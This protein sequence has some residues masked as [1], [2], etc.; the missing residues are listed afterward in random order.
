MSK[1]NCYQPLLGLLFY[2]ILFSASCT[3]TKQST[4]FKTLQQKDTTITGFIS[5]TYESKIQVGDKLSISV[6]SL[7]PTEDAIF[8]ASNNTT[9]TGNTTNIS[10]IEVQPNGTVQLHR[11]GNILAASL[12]RKELSKN[13]EK[14][15]LPYL[16]EPIVSVKYVN[17]KITIMGEVATPQVLNLPEEQISLIDALVLSGDVGINGKRNNVTI[18]RENGNQ[19]QI[20]HVNLEDHS[21]FTSPW[22][23]VQPNDIILV[24][25]DYERLEKLE[26]RA[27]LQ[28]NISLFTSIIS[29]VFIIVSQIVK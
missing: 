3:V 18:I 5:N 24:S 19:K 12:T 16:K 10:G 28:G 4:Y 8:N 6:S 22:Y 29:F 17:H 14:Q 9:T 13:L 27:K 20:K 26:R 25:S 15:L 11:V 21:I 2:I 7:S 23:Y 1:I